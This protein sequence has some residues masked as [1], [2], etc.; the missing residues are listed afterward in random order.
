MLEHKNSQQKK[1]FGAN[2]L[3]DARK[4]DSIH[5]ELA[6]G[7]SNSGYNDEPDKANFFELNNRK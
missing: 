6:G 7:G 3:T 2:K 4:F 1:N 5:I